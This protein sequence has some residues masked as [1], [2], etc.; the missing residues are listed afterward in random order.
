[1]PYIDPEIRKE[2]DPA[3]E[4]L[5]KALN[6]L[7]CLDGPVPGDLNYVVTRIMLEVTNLDIDPGYSKIND[8]IGM[9]EC[10][11]L[12]LYRKWAADYEDQKEEEN[13]PVTSEKRLQKKA[14]ALQKLTSGLT[15]KIEETQFRGRINDGPK[16]YLFGLI[17]VQKD[18]SGT[19]I[20][21]GRWNIWR[22]KRK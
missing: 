22:S 5:V 19:Q 17:E 9:L 15:G 6:G 1:M 11:K 16:K 2:L 12:E 20:S 3:I 8:M 10:C 13:G 7:Y 21:I 18:Y 4:G 14:E